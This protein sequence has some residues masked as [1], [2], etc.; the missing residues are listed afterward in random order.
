[1]LVSKMRQLTCRQMG[2]RLQADAAASSKV[3]RRALTR[4]VTPGALAVVEQAQRFHV[5]K[6]LG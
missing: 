2:G 4:Q 3:F 1:M 6:R 5:L